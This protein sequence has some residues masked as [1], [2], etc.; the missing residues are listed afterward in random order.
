VKSSEEIM[1]I[2]EA[3]DLTGGL[4]AAAQ[5]AGCD[6]KTVAHYVALR[7]AGASPDQRVRRP[8][9]IDPFLDK[10]EE[11][12]DRSNGQIRADVVHDKLVAMGFTGSDR[13]T[14]RAVS[15]AKKGWRAGHRRVFRPWIP[16]PGLWLQFDW[17]DGP[18]IAG[19]RTLLFCAWPAW[20]RFRVV[21]PTWDR[22]LPSLLACLDA[23]LRAVGEA[24]TYA[25]TDNEKTV[26]VEHIARVPV[27]HP[28]IVAAGW[29]YG[30]TIR[31]CVPADPQS[32]GGTEASVRVA[33]ADL[34][35][36]EANLLEQY[37]GFGELERACRVFC[38]QVNTR[39]HRRTGRAPYLRTAALD[40]IP[41]ARAQRWDPAEVLRV[42][43]AEEITGRDQATLRMRRSRANFPAG[44]TFAVWDETRCSIPAPTQAGK[45]HSSALLPSSSPWRVRG[46][47]CPSLNVPLP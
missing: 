25:L 3:Y 26:T 8:R 33:K 46:R 4:R 36:T 18:R 12:V 11:W 7:D 32:K 47:A 9:A 21:I 10:V 45:V 17:G 27:R 44:K 14:R 40:V 38:G 1:E 13:S 24:P 29:H 15:R 20:S 34:V 42:L 28:D 35:P 31:T 5:L 2:L 43:L 41:T 19:R 30:M 23:T 6:H 39:P 16:E 22:T 37:A